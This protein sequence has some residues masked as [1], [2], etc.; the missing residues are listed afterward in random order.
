MIGRCTALVLGAAAAVALHSQ[1]AAAIARDTVVLR[2]L[3]KI[4]GRVSTLEV[5]VGRTVEF[6]T[7][8]IIPWHCDEAPPEERLE[9]A[10][11][12]EIV[13]LRQ[14]EDPEPRFTGW[15]LASSPSLSALEHPVYDLWVIDCK[16][17]S[18]SESETS[19]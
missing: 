9:S 8:Q 15:M 4:T 19:E 12:L 1:P 17:A 5:A 7:L 3:D 14:D 6:G 10:A 13:E 11:F 16:N 2:A 18:T